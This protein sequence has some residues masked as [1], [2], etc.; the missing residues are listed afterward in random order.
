MA[1]P[2]IYH[3]KKRRRFPS[4]RR[5]SRSGRRWS[6]P[7]AGVLMIPLCVAAGRT[8]W[9]MLGNGSRPFQ[10]VTTSVP[11]LFFCSGLL[12]WM[13]VYGILPRPVKLYVLGHELTHA[14]CAWLSGGAAHRLRIG[15]HGGSVAV[16]TS[17]VFV[18]L[19]PYFLPLYAVLVLIAYFI[20]GLFINPAP[21]HAWWMALLG[22]SWGFHLTFTCSTLSFPQQDIKEYGPLFSYAMILFFNLLILALGLVWVGAPTFEEFIAV[23]TDELGIVARW[24]WRLWKAYNVETG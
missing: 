1:S 11:A 13:F 17:N 14:L 8:L 20:S 19:A 3:L 21:W 18:V 9:R 12:L 2:K 15:S 5:K 4:T 7:L 24:P 6:Y 10:E 22:L 16:T 23:F